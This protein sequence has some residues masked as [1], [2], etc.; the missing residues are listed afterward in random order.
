MY[1]L[2]VGVSPVFLRL[3]QRH[4]VHVQPHRGKIDAVVGKV[5]LCQFLQLGAR[6]RGVVNA[7]LPDLDVVLHRLRADHG[8]VA[9]VRAVHVGRAL[10]QQ[11]LSFLVL[12]HGDDARH[13]T[14]P[15]R[16][17]R[18]AQQ[19]LAVADGH[20]R[21]A[22]GVRQNP[23]VEIVA[24]QPRPR[25]RQYAV[26]RVEQAFH[27]AS[28]RVLARHAPCRLAVHAEVVRVQRPRK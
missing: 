6:L 9:D 10:Q 26:V 4:K 20:A 19:V 14:V 25:L 1:R 24:H 8:I 27:K 16:G 21:L 3:P 12:P 13:Q 22:R 23:D 28:P 5:R 7:L 17:Q 15:V 18:R 2:K 11:R